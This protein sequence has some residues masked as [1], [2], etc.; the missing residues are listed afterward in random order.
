MDAKARLIQKI[1]NKDIEA[2]NA[3]RTRQSKLES[4]KD[5]LADLHKS[6]RKLVA[7]VPMVEIETLP[8]VAD[9]ETLD[10]GCFSLELLGGSIRFESMHKAGQFGLQVTNIWSRPTFLTAIRPDVWVST[11]DAGERLT[12]TDD[13]ILEK[14]EDFV[15]NPP[16]STVSLWD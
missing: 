1:Q 14:L 12:L 11:K 8:A 3:A 10:N 15:D 4:F 2:Q 5:D 13:L 7:D 16:A 9:G 6:L